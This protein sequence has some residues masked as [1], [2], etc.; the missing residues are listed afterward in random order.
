MEPNTTTKPHWVSFGLFGLCSTAVGGGIGCFNGARRGVQMRR[1]SLDTTHINTGETNLLR[2]YTFSSAFKSQTRL[3]L[4][5][6]LV[7]P[8]IMLGRHAL[9]KVMMK[10]NGDD[11]SECS[12]AMSMFIDLF[13]IPIGCTSLAYSA[14]YLMGVS[15]VLKLS[16]GIEAVRRVF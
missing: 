10:Y 14:G 15:T 8:T 11:N 3:A 6:I 5:H 12:L 4:I 1:I 13:C 9:N 7:G 16:L 2:R